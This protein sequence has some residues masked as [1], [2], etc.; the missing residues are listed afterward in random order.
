MAALDSLRNAQREHDDA[1]YE[2]Q[3]L[4]D[5]AFNLTAHQ[6]DDPSR[7]WVNLVYRHAER[8]TATGEALN[9]AMNAAELGK[10]PHDGS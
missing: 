10:V 7:A 8:L 5:L 4:A 9:V 1:L 2:F 6:P 3:A